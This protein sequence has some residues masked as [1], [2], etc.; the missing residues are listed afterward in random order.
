MGGAGGGEG[1]GGGT[2]FVAWMSVAISG[3]S[4]RDFRMSLRSSRAT[5]PSV[6]LAH[7]GNRKF[8]LAEMPEHR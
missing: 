6:A 2:I 4:G 3:A 1:V 7:G 5:D 8:A